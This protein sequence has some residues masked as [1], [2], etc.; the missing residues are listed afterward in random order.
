VDLLLIL[1]VNVRILGVEYQDKQ[2]TGRHEGN[3]AAMNWCSMVV[4]I[5]S[6]VQACVA[7]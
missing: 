2:F 4:I 6:P 5:L 7:E 1:P 3:S